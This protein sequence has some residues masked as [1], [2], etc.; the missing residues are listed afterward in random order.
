MEKRQEHHMPLSLLASQFETLE[1]P[2]TC[3]EYSA[4]HISVDQ[5]VE[6]II[7]DILRTL[8]AKCGMKVS[9]HS[10]V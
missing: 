9:I 7:N 1:E 8:K 4:L 6:E 3:D 10:T 5:T 2:V